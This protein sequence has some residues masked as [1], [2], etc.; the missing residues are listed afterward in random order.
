MEEDEVPQKDLGDV[1]TQFEQRLTL[2]HR[3]HRLPGEAQD[4]FRAFKEDV[5]RRL[6]GD[7][8]LAPRLGGDRRLD[9]ARS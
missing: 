4:A 3:T 2:L 7:R 6:N 1:L 5:D 9:R 8:R